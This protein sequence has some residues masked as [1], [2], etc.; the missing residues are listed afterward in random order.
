MAHVAA[1]KS[2]AYGGTLSFDL[3]QSATNNQFEYS[4]VM[5]LGGG[6]MLVMD[7]SNTPRTMWTSYQVVLSEGNWHVGSLT[8]PVVT[9]AEVQQVLAA[10]RTLHPRGVSQR[11]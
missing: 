2:A 6:L 8:R 7:I 10:H 9:A 4:G 5:L 1:D 11:R 3:T